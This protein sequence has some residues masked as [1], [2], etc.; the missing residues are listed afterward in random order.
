MLRKVA[1]AYFLAFGVVLLV[2]PNIQ[3][4]FYNDMFCQ[5]GGGSG[6][7]RL[8]YMI[9]TAPVYIHVYA[10]ISTRSIAYNNF[11]YFYFKRITYLARKPVYGPQIQK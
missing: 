9:V 8:W 4:V 6:L 2:K 1:L 10:L 11:M 7:Q 3:N 5:G